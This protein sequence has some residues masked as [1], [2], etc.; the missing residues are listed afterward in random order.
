MR[1][2]D[3]MARH[4]AAVRMRHLTEKQ[5]THGTNPITG[6]PIKLPPIPNFL[7]SSSSTRNSNTGAQSNPSTASINER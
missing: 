6:E 1:D 5:N 7:L 2:A 4:R 3:Q